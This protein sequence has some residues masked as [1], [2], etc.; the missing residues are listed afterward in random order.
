MKHIAFCDESGI[1]SGSPCY[2]IGSIAIPERDFGSLEQ[3]LDEILRSRG[4]DRE[5]HWTDIRTS[6]GAAE[7]AIECFRAVINVADTNFAHAIVVLKSPYRKWQEDRE[8]AFYRTFSW[9]LAQLGRG[10]KS[11]LQVLMDDRSDSYNKRDEVLQFISSNMLK[12][13]GNGLTV[14]SVEKVD[15]HTFRLVQLADVWAGGINRSCRSFLEGDPELSAVR[16]LK[17]HVIE[18][19][20]SSLGTIYLTPSPW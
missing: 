6:E 14:E 20:A 3:Q 18:A 7:A 12:R 2:T 16:D 13:I 11:K 1:Q 19:L 4:V 10:T 9:L 5:L 17:R 15:S 8:E